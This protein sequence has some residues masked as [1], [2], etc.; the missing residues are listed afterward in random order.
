MEKINQTLKTLVPHQS[1][2]LGEHVHKKR[3]NALVWFCRSSGVSLRVRVLFFGSF[4]KAFPLGASCMYLVYSN[5]IFCCYIIYAFLCPSKKKIL[6]LHGENECK[7]TSFLFY[8]LCK[9][10]SSPKIWNLVEHAGNS[11]RDLRNCPTIL[12]WI[13]SYLKILCSS[14]QL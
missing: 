13:W 3:L 1:F 14:L 12:H 10:L 8:Y 6:N 5:V 11:R 7:D 9:W 2:S 4:F